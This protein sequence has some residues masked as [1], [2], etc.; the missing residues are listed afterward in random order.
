VS[1]NTY[2]NICKGASFIH[3]IQKSN[4]QDIGVQYVDDTSQFLNPLGLGI[5]SHTTDT[6]DLSRQ[7]YHQACKK[8]RTWSECLWMWGGC[9]NV[10]KCYFYSFH[11]DLNYKRN[12]ITYSDLPMP[13]IQVFDHVSSS[14]KTLQKISSSC[15]R[16]TLGV[17]MSPD[18]NGLSQIHHSTQKARELKGKLQIHP[19]LSMRNG[20]QLSP[21]LNLLFYIP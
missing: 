16:C 12:A 17:I 19:Y 13:D 7:L 11:P 14:Y 4:L 20:W 18:G 3:P 6:T 8:S 1:L 5:D 2:R 10:A 9:L 15:A 21:L